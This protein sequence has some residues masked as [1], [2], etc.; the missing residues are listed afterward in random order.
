MQLKQ[1]MNPIV[2][3]VKKESFRTRAARDFRRNS[4][5]YLM[6][7]PVV[8]FYAVFHY[9][10]LYGLQIAFKNFSAGLGIWNSPWVG[11]DHFIEFFNGFFFE[12]VVT[13]TIVLGLYDLIFV[14]PASIVL[15]L[16]LNEVRNRMFKR[17]VQ[18][19]TYIP[20]FISVVVVVGMLVDFL[21]V[22]G[23]IN[24]LIAY[25]GGKPISFMRLPEWFRTIYTSSAIWQGIGWGSIIYLAAISNIDPSLYEAAKVDGAGRWKQ[26]LMITLPGI[27]PT[28]IIL[29]ILRIGSFMALQDEKILIMYNPVT[30][31]TADVIGT[32]VY[33]KGILEA[34]YSFSAAVGM[35]NSLINFVLLIGANYLSKRFTE[36]KLW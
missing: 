4:V 24:Q 12:R 22:D 29:L 10:P 34:S 17:T 2:R 21:S 23:L 16:L 25:F 18:S 11:F 26:M 7:L 32:Y 33:R 27:M 19:I 31:E 28:V 1:E 5:I 14:F 6:L 35:F 13:N 3:P 36:T 9:G 20:H 30:Y 8:A 15:A